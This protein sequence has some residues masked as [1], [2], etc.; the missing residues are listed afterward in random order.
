[1]SNHLQKAAQRLTHHWLSSVPALCVLALVLTMFHAVIALNVH[2]RGVVSLLEDKLT[3]TVYLREDADAIEVG[4]LVNKLS[5]QKNIVDTVRYTSKDDALRLLETQFAFNSDLMSKYGVS[6]PPS[7]LIRPAHREAIPAIQEF[8]KKEAPTL[9]HETLNKNSIQQAAHDSLAKLLQTINKEAVQTLSIFLI[10]FSVVALF[11]IAGTMHLSLSK[12]H[13]EFTIMK[14]I[15][16][17]EHTITTPLIIEG[18]LLGAASFVLHLVF[19]LILPLPSIPTT[20]FYNAL[21]FEAVIVIAVAA[22]A[23]YAAGLIYVK[24][25]K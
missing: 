5:I 16:A 24:N 3:F 4:T 7:L 10:I 1:M 12:R 22:L 8:I 15:G 2:T 21:V 19:I 6:L 25:S 18:M 17:P 9:L 14:F 13:V 11:L 20:L 23:S